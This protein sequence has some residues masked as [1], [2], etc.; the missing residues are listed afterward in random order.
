[1]V[2]AYAGR[3][4]QSLPADLDAVSTRIKRLLTALRPSAV[5]GAAADGGDLLVVEAALGMASGPAVHVILPTPQAV[6]RDQSVR[7][8]WRD[9]FDRAVE[10]AETVESLDLQD[11]SEAYRAGN[12]AFLAR[13]HHLAGVGERA[14]VL[15]VAGAGEGEMVQDLIARGEL[16]TTPALR[17]DPGVTITERPRVFVAMPYGRKT[18]PERK[19]D[20]DCDLVYARILVPA[21]ENAQL[22]YRRADEEIDAGVILQPMIE[23]IADADLVIGDLATGN[24]NVGWELGL[25]HVM[26]ARQT[27]LMRPRGTSPPFDLN[28]LRHVGYDHDEHGLSDDAA[29]AAWAALAPYLDVRPGGPS[30]SPVEAVMHVEQWARV[31]RRAA[32]DERWTRLRAELALARDIAD[33]DLMLEVLER[34]QGLEDEPLRLLRAEAGVGLVR[35]G[36]HADARALLKEVVEGDGDMRRPEAHVYYAQALYQPADAG[37]DAYAEAE[38]VLKR[39]LVRRP[40]DPEVRAMLGAIAKRRLRLRATAAERETDLRLALDS[41]RADYER[42]LNAYYAGINVVAVGVALHLRYSDADAGQLVRELLPAVRVAAALAARRDPLDLYWPAAT[43]AECALYETLLGLDGPDVE[44]AYRQAGALRPPPGMLG[45]TLTQLELL[46]LLELP[47]AP[48]ARAEAG[49]RRGAGMPV[50]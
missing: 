4:A 36:R 9:R 30:D 49:L 44:Q 16:R 24:F 35:L 32:P 50:G 12:A 25:R 2:L 34:A 38:R 22:Y 37:L 19:L 31:S 14:V 6:F 28:A 42:D 17:I 18:D 10:R 5:V 21:L 7:E 27:L 26:R 15:A 43:L 47:E 40:G 1:M 20:L 13:A 3:R 46:R 39:V 8:D 48:L 45:S 23:W 11:G 41:Y 33:G 29:I